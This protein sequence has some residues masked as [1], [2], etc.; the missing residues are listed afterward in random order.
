MVNFMRRLLVV[1]FF[2]FVFHPPE[3]I[4]SV[5][6]LKAPPDTLI[7]SSLKFCFDSMKTRKSKNREK[8]P[9]KNFNFFL[10]DGWRMM[11]GGRRSFHNNFQLNFQ[12]KISASSSIIKLSA[13]RVTYGAITNVEARESQT[14]CAANAF[15][16]LKRRKSIV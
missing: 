9:L 16:M 12:H 1:F 2:A 8:F 10:S 13:T 4:L 15:R 3:H 7:T 5:F 11:T 6:M 14:R